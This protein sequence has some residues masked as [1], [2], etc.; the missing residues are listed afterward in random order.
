[1]YL[2]PNFEIY[3]KQ[4]FNNDV[5]ILKLWNLLELNSLNIGIGV[6]TQKYIWSRFP[7]LIISFQTQK[8]TWSILH[9][10]KSQEVYTKYYW[11]INKVSFYF[12]VF[13]FHLYFF[14]GSSFK[15]YFY[16]T[17]RIWSIN[18]VYWKYM[19]HIDF[20]V[21]TGANISLKWTNLLELIITTIKCFHISASINTDFTKLHLI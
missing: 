1:M 13:I 11:S 9:F 18:E 5:F 16:C 19:S 12:F 6:Q 8:Y 4:T 17:S 21:K 3:L 2:S 20:S 7:K 15:A 10:R 14:S